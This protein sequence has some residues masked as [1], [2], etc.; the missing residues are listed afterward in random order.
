V[1]QETVLTIGRTAIWTALT[2]ASPVL[3]LTLAVGLAVS[4]F[5]ATTQIH[6]QTL[7]FAPKIVAA[8]LA[9]L[10][11]GAWMLTKLMDLTRYLIGNAN[12]F[13]R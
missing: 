12:S 9:L 2:V 3:G 13:V 1:T 7:T 5:Q 10:I 4:I 6:E 11:F 8:L